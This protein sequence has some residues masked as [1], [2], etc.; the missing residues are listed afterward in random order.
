LVDGSMPAAANRVVWD[1]RNS[2]GTPAA[3]G[4]YFC[5]AQVGEWQQSRKLVLLR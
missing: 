2:H 1:G 5:R 3:S 4:I